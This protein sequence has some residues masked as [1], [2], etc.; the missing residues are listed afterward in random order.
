[1]AKRW[2]ILWLPV[3][4]MAVPALLPAQTT[5][6]K[7]FP[8]DQTCGGGPPN[9]NVKSTVTS[10]KVNIRLAVKGAGP[11]NLPAVRTQDLSPSGIPVFG[12]DAGDA[13]T[14]I[15]VEKVCSAAVAAGYTCNG[16]FGPSFTACDCIPANAIVDCGDAGP[17]QNL[18]LNC[19]NG[20]S[21]SGFSISRGSGAVKFEVSPVA[22]ASQIVGLNHQTS[23]GNTIGT[24]M[25]PQYLLSVLPN[26]VLGPVNFSV[27]HTQGGSN[28]RTFSVNVTS[29]LASDPIA[30]HNAIASGFEGLGLGLTAL[31]YDNG[32]RAREVSPIFR[33]AGAFVRIPNAG[34]KVSQIDVTGAW[35]ATQ[36][37]GQDIEAETGEAGLGNPHIPTLNPLGLALL[38]VV[39]L[40][41][42]L[43]LLRRR[44]SLS[45]E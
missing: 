20:G 44:Q 28:P 10:G 18:L 21:T 42:G 37:K 3:L 14:E 1:M 11:G 36:Q 2:K 38:V 8:N 34:V 4:L 29:A 43:W 40:L 9:A 35:D 19:T 27:F 33:T 16:V 12:C 5:A 13:V 7:D 25:R 31:T 24:D 45:Q 23:A 26:G 39:L 30:L 32:L 22:P 41:S 15:S 6:S 17:G